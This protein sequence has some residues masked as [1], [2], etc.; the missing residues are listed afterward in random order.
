MGMRDVRSLPLAEAPVAEKA[1]HSSHP[2]IRER[3]LC[4]R[5]LFLPVRIHPPTRGGDAAIANG[6]GTG[7]RE[8]SPHPLE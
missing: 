3:P 8:A 1:R 2:R 5:D 6:E 4:A 7:H